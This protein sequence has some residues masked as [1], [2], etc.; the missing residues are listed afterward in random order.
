MVAVFFIDLRGIP[1][2]KAVCADPLK[3][4]VV[5]HDV[6]LFL[7]SPFG[8]G[9]NQV[10]AADVVAQAV[11]LDVLLDHQRHCEQAALAR[12][13]LNNLQTVPVS[14]PADIPGV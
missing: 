6:K 10:I 12:F 11:V 1:L 3:A 7:Y 4:Q 2:A 9:E 8:D 14:V 13:L 5:A